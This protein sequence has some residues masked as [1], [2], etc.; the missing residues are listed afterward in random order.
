MPRPSVAQ[1][2]NPCVINVIAYCNRRGARLPHYVFAVKEYRCALAQRLRSGRNPRSLHRRAHRR[3][4]NGR[5]GQ[6]LHKLESLGD[7]GQGRV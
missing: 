3:P 6:H 4:L 7:L 5:L 1:T 2:R